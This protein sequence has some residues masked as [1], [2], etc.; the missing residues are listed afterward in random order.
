VS[1][2][3]PKKPIE[4]TETLQAPREELTTGS[5]FAGRYQIIEELGKGGMGKVYKADDIELKEK[6]A[7]KLI[8]PEISA[9]KNTVERFQNELKF[10]R[11]IVH[12]NVGRM[13]DLGKEEG[14]YY[15]TMEYV[16]GQDLKGLIRQSGQL[17]IGTTISIAKQI[18]EGLAEAHKLG[19][20]HRDLKPSNIMVDRDGQ[21]RIMDF[22]IARSLK[23]KGITGAGVI[24]GTPEYM[25]PEQV[26]GK[27]VDHRSDIYSLGAILF[28]MVTGRVPFEGDTPFTVG[29]KHKSEIPVDPREINAQVP[30]DLSRIIL[31]CLE[32]EREIRYQSAGEVRSELVKIAEG[33]P[34]TEKFVASKKPMTSKEITVTLSKKKILI[35]ALA[36]LVLAVVAV[37]VVLFLPKEIPVEHSMAVITFENQTG[38]QSYD[39]LQKAIPNLLITSLEQSNNISVVTWERMHDLLDLMGKGDVEVIDGDL[40]FELCRQNG[41]EAIVL[42]S[43]V[44]AGEMFATD[45]K[46]LDV[47]TKNLLKSTSSRGKG[48]DSILERQIDELSKEISKGVGLP[49]RT[50]D[51]VKARIAD[52]TTTSME[53]YDYYLKGREAN[54]K[55]YHE[56]GKQYLEK[57]VELDPQFAVA[58]LHLWNANYQ[59]K[60]RGGKTLELLRKAK[61]Y[62]EKATEKERLYILAEYA[63]SIERDSEKQIR[64]LEE[65]TEKYPN[66]KDAYV[67]LGF[68][69]QNRGLLED[70]IRENKKALELAPN[71]GYILNQLGYTYSDM[72]EYEKAVECFETYA[73]LYPEDANPVDSMAEQY[74]RMGRLDE[75]IVNYKKVLEIKPDFGVGYRIA[76]MYALKEDFA[77]AMFWLDFN[78]NSVPT[79]G[80]KAEGFLW[81]GIY[82]FF[83]GKRDM[84]F[85]SLRDSYHWG[86]IANDPFRKLSIDY[87]R[88]WWYY[89]LNEMEL[90]SD[91]LQKAWDVLLSFSSNSKSWRA[92]YDFNIGLVEVKQ[93]K[94]ESAHARL[95]EIK[96]FM[97]EF[98]PADNKSSVYQSLILE[99]EILMAEGSPGRAIEVLKKAVL[100]DIP[101]LHTDA[102]GPYNIPFLRDFLAR[103]C[104]QSGDLDGAIAEY[105]SLITFDPDSRD[106][107]LIHPKYHLELAKLYEE[108][109]MSSKAIQQYEIFLELWKDADPGLVEVE[110]ARKRLASLKNE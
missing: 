99:A 30:E 58:Y 55:F 41:I 79:P 83:L 25:S 8:K 94:M 5:A 86:E 23:G 84:A 16:E 56:E 65:L 34:T 32:K 26:E 98:S 19:V 2:E 35:P 85:N 45:V 110:D 80:R 31:K 13:Y 90:S 64:I 6:V 7:L 28:E 105:E 11:K 33:L 20:I 1:E 61:E 92:R 24:I 59:L 50:V 70:S 12:K 109:G 67:E 52:V 87:I 77:E 51:A 75:A 18:C 88:G 4:H 106:R 22:G 66:E 36:I 81:K 43:Y 9:D 44:K 62:S 71:D 72:G 39:Y 69:Y 29:V 3:K 48:I 93:R 97:P 60:S 40:G 74:F 21:V 89:E 104:L 82:N 68:I 37:V 101:S 96:T 91:Y 100:P 38:E 108:K 17:A 54:D 63:K 53:A 95:L 57:A 14:S 10:A 15:I 46:V 78:I 102:I 27:D 42:G 73:N 107:Y 49:S 103:A 47:R 76:Y